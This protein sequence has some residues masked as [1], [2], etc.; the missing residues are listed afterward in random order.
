M[1]MLKYLWPWAEI[2]RLER[3]LS[4]VREESAGWERVY[5]RDRKGHHQTRDRLNEAT[6]R[7]AELEADK[8]PRDAKG[9]MAPKVRAAAK[10]EG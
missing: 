9:R 10:G 6:A 4:L 7:I 8:Q 3:E 5:W 2:G 1:T